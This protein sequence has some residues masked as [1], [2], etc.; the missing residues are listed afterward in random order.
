M[1]LGRLRRVDVGKVGDCSHG[2]VYSCIECDVDVWM[3]I[4]N[5]GLL[6]AYGR[7][8][9]R[10]EEVEWKQRTIGLWRGVSIAGTCA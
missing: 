6:T 8:Q 10:S 5:S 4:F 2:W 7:L 3:Y 1:E 9:E